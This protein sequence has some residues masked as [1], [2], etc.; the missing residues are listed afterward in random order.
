MSTASN[1]HG[2]TVS[3]IRDLADFYAR[4]ATAP[5]DQLIGAENEKPPFY[6]KDNAPG[7]YH[8][9]KKHDG[10]KDVFKTLADKKGWQ[11]VFEGQNITGLKRDGANWSFEPSLQTETSGAPF[12][13]VHSIAQETDATIGEAVKVARSHGIRF[14][15]I[16]YHP[17]HAPRDLP[18]VPRQRYEV[19]HAFC[20]RVGSP[21]GH[22]MMA[23]TSTVQA[24]LNYA[25]EED[26]VLK[27]RVSLA[28]QPIVTAL[29]AN[30]P[31]KDGKPSGF[32]SYRSHNNHNI[33]GGRYGFMFP[34][35]FQPGFGYEKLAEYF[36][37]EVPMIGLYKGNVF[38]DAK[39]GSFADFMQ[40]KLAVVPG[41]QATTT[42]FIN[43]VKTIFPE[44][45]P[46]PAPGV[47]E[48][49]GADTG[50]QEMIKAL[51]ALWAGILY[52]K[53]SLN[54]A[55][56]MV[57][58]WSDVDREYLRASVPRTGLQTPIHGTTVQDI[59]KKMLALASEGLQRRNILNAK[60]ADERI[61]LEPLHE[62]ADSGRNWAQRL[63]ERYD[64]VWKGD[65]SR[66]LI[67]QDYANSPSV[68]KPYLPAQQKSRAISAPRPRT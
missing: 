21:Q 14:V 49:R 26:M 65:I 20:D 8:G 40:G 30:S 68:L 63:L 22:G 61:Y 57:K 38:L 29:Y 34:E 31:F 44:V 2:E 55:W 18:E 58:G 10:L 39:G 41:Q 24:N 9:D 28:L 33:M 47:L 25:S 1:A 67:E 19:M 17:T 52:D 27:L 35:A 64:N 59:A 50:P 16:A 5:K 45:R 51:P 23:S 12:N 37:R 32:E 4:G 42:D 54:D 46:Q 60:G 53:K 62:I 36:A 7:S 43:H 66:L 6:I 11:P 15:S 13:N 56:E 3:S 48:M